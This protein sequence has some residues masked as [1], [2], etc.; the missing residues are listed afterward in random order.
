M[1][2]IQ[3]NINEIIDQRSLIN[4]V[5]KTYLCVKR[6]LDIVVS[7]LGIL[8]LSSI[9]ITTAIWIKI[10]LRGAVLHTE[11]KYGLRG[12][13][14]ITYEFSKK[15][16]NTYISKLPLLFNILKGNMSLVGPQPTLACDITR[17]GWYILRMSAKPGITGLWQVSRKGG[18]TNEMVQMDLKYIRERSLRNDIKIILKAVGLMFREKRS[19]DK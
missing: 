16:K 7:L 5:S 3:S 14:F 6:F 15:V 2:K 18:E 10:H 12:T 8:L 13:K 4:N 1:R 17:D 9:L 11:E 19:L